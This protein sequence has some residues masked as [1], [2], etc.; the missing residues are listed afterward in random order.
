MK[1]LKESFDVSQ[2][3]EMATKFAFAFF[4]NGFGFLMT[5]N[6]IINLTDLFQ[7]RY[8]KSIMFYMACC[9]T[10][11]L[12]CVLCLFVIWGHFENI[13]AE[14]VF[15]YCLHVITILGMFFFTN[16]WL[17]L[18]FALLSGIGTGIIQGVL[19]NV[20]ANFPERYMLSM[21]I[22]LSFSGLLA[23]SIRIFTR[24]LVPDI[25]VSAYLYYF[26]AITVIIAT[27]ALTIQWIFL[28]PLYDIL[29]EENIVKDKKRA[30]DMEDSLLVT[31]NVSTL[32]L[33]LKDWHWLLA[34]WINF[35]LTMV[36]FP[37]VLSTLQSSSPILGHGWFPILQIL[38]F[39][40][41]DVIIRIVLTP[42][43]VNV[44]PLIIL[45]LSALRIFF[46]PA[47]SILATSGNDTLIICT[48][49]L[50]GLSNGYCGTVPMI[51]APNT[52]TK[53]ESQQ[54]IG[55]LMAFTLTLGLVCGS[56]LG[57]VFQSYIV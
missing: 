53:P 48:T 35:S 9:L 14:L 51:R 8:G 31:S 2:K 42:S 19:Y 41:C 34:V 28:N 33:A 10:F 56:I 11:P 4:V 15:G 30:P 27:L 46:I 49:I 44:G 26:F 50:F 21:Q 25:T 29:I 16:M 36:I 22:G 24:F 47:F 23:S 38:L 18:F 5:Y 3:K 54:V 40:A 32:S 45:F 17:T 52:V 43:I 1:M 37:G 6:T 57:A 39:G 13:R 55:S 7:M 20:L 12:V